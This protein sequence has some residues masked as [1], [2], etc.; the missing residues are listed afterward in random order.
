MISVR[1]LSVA[2]SRVQHAE[3]ELKLAREE[4]SRIQRDFDAQTSELRANA[5]EGTEWHSHKAA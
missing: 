2:S 4:L 1:E 5:P 3:R